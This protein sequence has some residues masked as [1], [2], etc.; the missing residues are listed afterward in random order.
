MKKIISILLLTFIIIWWFVQAQ[1]I[2]PQWGDVA[3]Y[4]SWVSVWWEV[5]ERQKD[6]VSNWEMS[7]WDQ[8]ASWIMGW[9]TI[10]DYCAY[11]VRFL[12]EVALL[13]W[14]L[15]SIYVWYKRI[16]KNLFPE[17]PKGLIMV[18]VWLLIVIAAY[19]IV[20]LLWSAF[21]S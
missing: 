12:W 13:I 15:A 6:T 18:I 9:D 19:V 7:L 1:S 3:G 8:L 2:I 16:F 21:I 20:K 10:L 17:P 5:L 14:A 11:L 4:V